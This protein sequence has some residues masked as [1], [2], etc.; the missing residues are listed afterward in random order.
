[1]HI[2]LCVR[3]NMST[4]LNGWVR[5]GVVLSI[6]WI[7]LVSG[8]AIAEYLTRNPFDYFH[9]ETREQIFFGWAKDSLYK[10]PE[11]QPI[12]GFKDIEFLKFWVTL[13]VPIIAAWL[14]VSALYWSISWI[15]TGFRKDN[16]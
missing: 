7:V 13:I 4:K 8:V 3:E 14:I 9:N 16:V 15:R 1:M 11:G 6:A 12:E 5:L 10:T 2:T